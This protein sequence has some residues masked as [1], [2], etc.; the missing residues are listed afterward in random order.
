MT[1]IDKSTPRLEKVRIKSEK[2][3]G[4]RVRLGVNSSATAHVF[5]TNS[6]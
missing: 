6:S 4:K 2:E 3:G 1:M 5:W